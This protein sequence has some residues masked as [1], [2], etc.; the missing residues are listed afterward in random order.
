MGQTRLQPAGP[1]LIFPKTAMGWAGPVIISV[2]HEMC[3]LCKMECKL[4]GLVWRIF[5]LLRCLR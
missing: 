1:G 2:H 3:I 5:F 4:V